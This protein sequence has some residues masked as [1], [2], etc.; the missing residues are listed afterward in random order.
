[1]EKDMSAESER[2]AA[3]EE[4]V[5]ALEARLQVAETVAQRAYGEAAVAGQLAPLALML[6][7]ASGLVDEAA[8]FELLDRLLLRF[9]EGEG[10][11]PGGQEALAYARSRLGKTLQGF[12]TPPPAR[13]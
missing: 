3:L 8:L 9:E 13:S 6:I 11:F 1:M 10:S 2:I 4:R 5:A 12:G 7:K